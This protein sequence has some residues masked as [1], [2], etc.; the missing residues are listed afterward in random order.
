[1]SVL[2]I[3]PSKDS[4]IEKIYHSEMELL[5]KMKKQVDAETY[6]D[7]KDVLSINLTFAPHIIDFDDSRIS[8]YTVYVIIFEENDDYLGHVWY[9]EHEN[10]PSMC[11]IF[12]MSS[13]IKNM[14]SETPVKGISRKIIIEGV[15]PLAK[16]R[17][18]TEIIV[19]H[20]LPAMRHV[21]TFLGFKS[22]KKPSHNQQRL[23]LKNIIGTANYFSLTI[24]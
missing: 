15:I 3:L 24:A 17:K 22:Y 13:S 2:Y 9:F 6:N 18:K 14:L 21:L 23:F 5:N 1:M 20:P 4:K 12:G 10:F 19:P 16:S 8:K 7:V 11:G